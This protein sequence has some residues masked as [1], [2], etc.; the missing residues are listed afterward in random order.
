MS[1]MAT[2]PPSPVHHP[3]I[4]RLT[5][6]VALAGVGAGLVAIVGYPLRLAVNPTRLASQAVFRCAAIFGL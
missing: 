1:A 5:V 6:Q 3:Q 4:E 2:A